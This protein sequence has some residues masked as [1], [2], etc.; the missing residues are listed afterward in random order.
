MTLGFQGFSRAPVLSLREPR[1]TVHPSQMDGSE[2]FGSKL[3]QV[4]EVFFG[5]GLRCIMKF[6][7]RA[8]LDCRSCFGS[9]N[10]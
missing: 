9:K 4:G 6:F 5:I 10:E 3:A 2:R 1:V 7:K 8:R